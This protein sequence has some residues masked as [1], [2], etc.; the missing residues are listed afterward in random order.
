MNTATTIAP[1]VQGTVWR[2]DRADTTLLLV[3]SMGEQPRILHYGKVLPSIDD[4]SSLLMASQP[5]W[6]HG[7][8]DDRAFAGVFPQ[9]ASGFGG[10]PALLAHADGKTVDAL[11][12][13]QEV[14]ESEH[15][16]TFVFFSEALRVELKL[17]LDQSGVLVAMSTLHNLAEHDLQVDWLAAAS[18]EL[19]AIPL[20]VES[21]HGRWGQEL[22]CRRHALDETAPTLENR[23]G[24]SSHQL[25]PGMLAGEP[26]FGPARGTCYAMQLAW[27]GNFRL[28]AQR[29]FDGSAILQAGVLYLPGE[30][31]LAAGQ[32]MSSPALLFSYGEGADACAQ[33]YHR[34]VR[35]HVLPRW[36]R[37]ERPIHSNSWEALYFDLDT[38]KLCELVDAAVTIGAERFV[39]DDGWFHGRRDD[40]A[41]LGDWW[42]DK[43]IFPDGLQPL[44]DHVRAAGLQFGLWFE[45][46]MVNPNSDLY[47]AH[48]DWVLSHSGEDMPLARQQ[49]VLDI[50]KPEVSEYLFAQISALVEQYKIDYIKWDMNRDLPSA[51]DG[52]HARAAAQP[53]ALYALMQ[54]LNQQFPAL[55]IESCSSGGA[56]SDIG[57][58]A[59]TGRVW[60][61]DNND[62]V[63]RF[64]IHQAASQFLPPEIL[65][66]HIGPDNAHLTGRVTPVHTRAVQAMTGQFG[67]EL[68]PR[69]L[70]ADEAEVLS[71]Y[72]ALYK[73]HRGWLANAS[74]YRIDGLWPGV[75]ANVHVSAD[76]S[77]AMLALI[78]E[79]SL[80]CA[81]AGRV[82]VPGL[83]YD[84]HYR[85]EL[86]IADR[87]ELQRRNRQMPAWV[88]SGVRM[89]GGVLTATGLAL[90]VLS[91]HSGLLILFERES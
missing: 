21:Y 40:R 69:A 71:G 91:T 58:L 8:L 77:Q 44:V 9:A 38:A 70:S 12:A 78:T 43:D 49:L 22:Q 60:T 73:R 51:G 18:L 39:L 48:P 13:L 72:A 86:V 42:V 82:V 20:E 26:G 33:R 4:S 57:V 3:A 32:S 41:G 24:R 16:L 83:D 88:D 36:S 27:S 63:D 90:P 55:E 79:H 10:Q 87:E 65:G 52:Q 54:R 34:Y 66:A 15:A 25:F 6:P 19:P 67:Y 1:E 45:P 84:A 68:D 29:Q 47:R 61:S 31:R 89:T 62:P 75:I 53:Q 14:I 11:L 56:R 76:S 35:S 59:H 64:R 28:Q 80:H 74:W 23:R 37:T 17:E 5:G 30:A 85:V 46:E 2:L 81:T 50:A 7:T